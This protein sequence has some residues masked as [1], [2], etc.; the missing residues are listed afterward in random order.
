[1]DSVAHSADGTLFLKFNP[2]LT[3]HTKVQKPATERWMTT[4]GTLLAGYR[5]TANVL[6]VPLNGD[7]IS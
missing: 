1:M 4:P 5:T 7:K 3:G 6:A 2:T